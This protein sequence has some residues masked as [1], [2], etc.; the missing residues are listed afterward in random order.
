MASVNNMASPPSPSR[1]R[2]DSAA[3]TAT[4]VALVLVAGLL[5]PA[6]CAAQI[7]VL[8]PGELLLLVTVPGGQRND[9][10]VVRQRLVTTL[11]LPSERM[12]SASVSYT[13]S[14]ETLFQ[15]IITAGT[16][17]SATISTQA[18]TLGTATL[19]TIGVTRIALV[20][21]TVAASGSGD[22]NATTRLIIIIA[23]AAAG[24]ALV[25]L[26]LAAIFCKPRASEADEK[27]A[28]DRQEDARAKAAAEMQVQQLVRSAAFQRL[29]DRV[30]EL[31]KEEQVRRAVDDVEEHAKKNRHLTKQVARELLAEPF[32]EPQDR[33]TDRVEAAAGGGS[34][35]G[36]GRVSEAEMRKQRAI[37]AVE[38]TPPWWH[39][40]QLQAEITADLVAPRYRGV[41]DFAS[42]DDDNT[43]DARRKAAAGGGGGG[44][45]AARRDMARI[46]DNLIDYSATKMLSEGRHWLQH[47]PLP[48]ISPKTAS[49]VMLARSRLHGLGVFARRFIDRG[50]LLFP[51]ASP[52]LANSPKLVYTSSEMRF[53]FGAHWE[54]RLHFVARDPFN[55]KFCVAETPGDRGWGAMINSC[56]GNGNLLVANCEC[57]FPEDAR[58]GLAPWIRVTQTIAPLAELLLDYPFPEL[59]R[60]QRG[61]LALDDDPDEPAPLL[62][63]TYFISSNLPTMETIAAAAAAPP[64]PPPPP[65]PP[66][67]DAPSLAGTYSA[68]PPPPLPLDATVIDI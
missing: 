51:Y 23:G 68:V 19:A 54:T 17:S 44:E 21:T 8:L 43:A 57:V 29:Q 24:G 7:R 65:P 22:D 4:L 10:D 11:S 49:L 63:S 52:A 48:K 18:V 59:V 26:V 27:R 14:T 45:G 53:N 60:K 36:G 58:A 30:I 33:A 55:K 42:F 13:S 41:L 15:F 16:P 47:T 6:L 46:P 56:R 5:A 25:A 34:P 2:S 20:A 50:T 1:R 64:P 62:F 9:I 37:D 38:R 31:E 12:E 67:D 66:H 28:R 3:W 40:A 61:M 35:R 39:D 32:V